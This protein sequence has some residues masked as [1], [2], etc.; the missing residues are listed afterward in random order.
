MTRCIL[1]IG[2]T[3]T[4]SS[5]IQRS[6][7]A[8]R[9]QLAQSGIAYF[10]WRE[11]HSYLHAA[12][13]DD[14]AGYLPLRRLGFDT[15]QARAGFAREAKDRLATFLAASGPEVKVISGEGLGDFTPQAVT[16]LRDLL[17]AHS[18][19]TQVVVY[20]RAPFAYA[21]S[22]A[23]QCV[24]TG[25][26][27]EDIRAETLGAETLGTETL[28]AETLGQA[29]PRMSGGA[30]VRPNYR[31]R[32][33]KFQ[34]AFGPEA[35]VIRPFERARLARGDVVEDFLRT[36]FGRD[37]AALGIAPMRVNESLDHA[38]VLCIEAVN[39]S[40][41]PFI[42]GQRNPA[43]AETLVAGFKQTEAATPFRMPGF[44]W[45]RFVEVIADDVAWLAETTGGEIAFPLDP[46]H[47]PA[48]PG[49]VDLGA[50]GDLLN[51]RMRELE[52]ARPE[53]RLLAYLVRL[54]LGRDNAGPRMTEALAQIK[55][56][57]L[58]LPLARL[59]SQQG[60]AELAQHAL[61]RAGTVTAPDS[62]EQARLG[63][64][65]AQLADRSEKIP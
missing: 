50:V 47:W 26:T 59:L 41:P 21:N 51:R 3:K 11:N 34:Q 7:F 9:A 60:H 27:F 57:A 46:G 30:N 53:A 15:A 14:L 58:L 36:A 39:R 16:A 18:A 43:R 35:V 38:A 61:E 63:R 2:T 25:V 45:P 13:H 64:L 48:P 12:F 55:D 37:A 65:R 32:I 29:R 10:D 52:K 19:D 6:C 40:A 22:Q 33:E 4:G 20:V 62:P 8:Q 17:A 31:L 1:H 56:T 44:D 24:K 5:S 49:P 28:G 42:D 23:Q 54:L